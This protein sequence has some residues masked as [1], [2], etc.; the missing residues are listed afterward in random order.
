MIS[1]FVFQIMP[2]PAMTYKKL[3][4]QL[5][6][7][8]YYQ[9]CLQIFFSWNQY[10]IEG[11]LFFLY[12]LQPLVPEASPLVEALLHDLLA[13]THNLKKCKEEK[14]CQQ[15]IQKPS[16]NDNV[17]QI[18]KEKETE[19]SRVLGLQ[20]KIKDLELLYQESLSVI[21]NLHCEIEER[22][23]KILKLELSHNVQIVTEKN[24]KPMLSKPRIEMT[25][26]V[27]SSSGSSSGRYFL[28][29]LGQIWP[30]SALFVCS[31]GPSIN[32]VPI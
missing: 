1:F 19:S 31:S 14:Y 5:D 2:A 27:S 12:N 6:D 26:L 13:T 8:G 20:K 11:L 23:A 21:K 24:S 10:I 22:N 9:V 15:D 25:S 32:N 29:T 7:L 3:R 16:K 28:L 17:N 4:R 18:L 30:I